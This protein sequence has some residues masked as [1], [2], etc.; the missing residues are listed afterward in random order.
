MTDN[1]TRFRLTGP[2]LD[3]TFD[4]RRLRIALPSGLGPLILVRDRNEGAVVVTVSPFPPSRCGGVIVHSI[5]GWFPPPFSLESFPGATYTEMLM[6]RHTCEEKLCGGSAFT[7][8]TDSSFAL[9]WQALTDTKNDRH[10]YTT[11]G[12]GVEQSG[13][14]ALLGSARFS[15]C[16]TCLLTRFAREFASVCEPPQG[17]PAH[18]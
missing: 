15:P 3:N 16:L 11:V 7:P 9:L 13:P 2:S 6:R 1:S 17:R 5:S 4:L 14:A 10:W 18:E 8:S 12:L